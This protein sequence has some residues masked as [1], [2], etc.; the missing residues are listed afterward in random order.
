[1]WLAMGFSAKGV[2]IGDSMKYYSVNC[3]DSLGDNRAQEEL[4]GIWCHLC[5][6]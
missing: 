6:E 4:L 3:H 1:M 5:K 2:H